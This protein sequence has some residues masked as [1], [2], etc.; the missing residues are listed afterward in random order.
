MRGRNKRQGIVFDGKYSEIGQPL[1]PLEDSLAD[2]EGQ[3]AAQLLIH[4]FF[5]GMTEHGLPYHVSMSLRDEHYFE[6]LKK[7]VPVSAIPK[8]LYTHRVKEV[9]IQPSHGDHIVGL[10]EWVKALERQG[11]FHTRELTDMVAVFGNVDVKYRVTAL[12]FNYRFDVDDLK[13]REDM[14]LRLTRL[15]V[16]THPDYPAYATRK[17]NEMIIRPDKVRIFGARLYNTP[18]TLEAD[19]KRLILDDG[20]IYE[21]HQKTA[22]FYRPFKVIGHFSEGLAYHE[23]PITD[24]ELLLQM[25]ECLLAMP[26]DVIEPASPLEIKFLEEK[27]KIEKIMI[28]SKT[29]YTII[30]HDGQKQDE[31]QLKF[32]VGDVSYWLRNIKVE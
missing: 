22:E 20:L 29:P 32:E 14:F 11:R 4:E 24:S 17:G 18:I 26:L 23:G 28:N 9:F 16:D 7:L 13:E 5:Q 6:E 15:Y 1:R 8:A 10:A 27:G 31:D 21:I 25:Q 2:E 30:R 12:P 19:P 3:Y